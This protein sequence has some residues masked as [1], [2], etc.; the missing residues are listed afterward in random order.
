METTDYDFFREAVLAISSSLEL[1]KALRSLF[2]FIRNYIPIK[3]LTLHRFAPDLRSIHLHFLVTEKEYIHMDELVPLPFDTKE[4][5]GI[6]NVPDSSKRPSTSRY[7]EALKEHLPNKNRAYLFVCLETEDHVFGHLCLIGQNEN[8]FTKEHE[9]LIEVLNPAVS[10]AMMNLLQ[11]QKT[12]KLQNQLDQHRQRLVNEVRLLKN[13]TIIGTYDG[14][15]DIM[16]MVGQLAG[17]EIPVLILG[18]T[19]T[20]KELLADAVHAVSLR[21]DQPYIKVNCGAIPETLVDSELFGYRKGAFTGAN[22]DR[23]GRF[24]Q[25]DGGTL[26]LD[27]VGDLPLPLQVRLLRVLQNGV[28]ERLGSDRS[29][30]VDI[31]IIA[32]TNR[33]L[34]AMVQNGTFREDLYYRLNVF[35]I[36]LPPLRDRIS[37]LPLLIH[38]FIEKISRKFHLPEIPRLSNNSLEIL[39]SYSWPGNVRELE[40]LLE[41]TITISPSG[42]LQPEKYLQK[43]HKLSLKVDENNDHLRQ[44]ISG[45]VKEIL[46]E[47][48]YLMD[49]FQSFNRPDSQN[50]EVKSL[51]EVMADHIKLVLGQCNGK[52]HGKGGAA[53]LLG[54]HSSTLRKRMDKLKIPYGYKQNRDS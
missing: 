33:P 7:N 20:G 3:G 22:S 4:Q 1:P 6:L 38:H 44:L 15:K 35:P 31:R 8:C 45:H 26:F 29:I 54:I 12:I 17:R 19:G 41:R 32:A 21:S 43:E 27:E 47:K 50:T 37:D 52:I 2:N 36:H 53:E 46:S 18:E 23:P 30:P 16:Q 10:L 5:T 9:H 49:N 39:K 24:E 11:Y 51:D 42:P 25:A 14:L 48:G 34:V 28:I 40:N 13:K